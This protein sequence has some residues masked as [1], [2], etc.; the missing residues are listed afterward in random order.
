[1]IEKKDY[2]DSLNRRITTYDEVLDFQ[3]RQDIY[4]FCMNSKFR[5]GW[6]DSA[7]TENQYN[8]F[9][10]SSFS[11]DDLQSLGYLNR[12]NNSPIA[13]ELEGYRVDQCILNL[14]TPFD[15]YY[16]HCHSH[17]K[18]ILLY[19][20]LE[21]RDGY[22]GETLFFNEDMKSIFLATPYTPGRITVFDPKIPHSI[23]PHSSRAPFFRFTLATFLYKE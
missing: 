15:T 16:Q 19:V 17:D 22:H 9:L 12:L 23:R 18:A 2:Y 3:F 7:I 11:E 20:N 6:A 5:I 10:Y 21:W 8:K 13:H 1:M 14:T 4:M